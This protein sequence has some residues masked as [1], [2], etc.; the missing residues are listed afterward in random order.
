MDLPS[1]SPSS[2]RGGRSGEWHLAVRKWLS[3]PLAAVF[4]SPGLPCPE[5]FT[6]FAVMHLWKDLQNCD[7]TAIAKIVEVN[8][9][10]VGTREN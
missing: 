8:K 5:S 1:G 4:K 7:P 10:I 2:A 9:F 3:E 6:G